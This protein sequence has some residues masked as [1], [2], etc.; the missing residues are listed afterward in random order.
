MIGVGVV[1]FVGVD[2]IEMIVVVVDVVC[3]VI[4]LVGVGYVVF[5]YGL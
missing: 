4:K 5:M 3:V 1:V 2:C